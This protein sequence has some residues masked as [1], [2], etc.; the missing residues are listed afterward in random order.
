MQRQAA[1][2][3][4]RPLCVNCGVP[5]PAGDAVPCFAHLQPTP[6]R[7]NTAVTMW[8]SRVN[9]PG[10]TPRPPYGWLPLC[11]ALA[12]LAGCALVHNYD[13]PDGPRFEGHYSSASDRSASELTVGT[14]N[15]QFAT[16]VSTAIDEIESTPELRD[17]GVLLLQEMDN[18]GSDAIA[19]HFGFDY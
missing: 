13:D 5:K 2:V 18:A 11:F 7:P 10:W 19:A 6:V 9:T 14:F 4:V 17:S 3:G 12:P 8:L 15:I 1:V 16:H